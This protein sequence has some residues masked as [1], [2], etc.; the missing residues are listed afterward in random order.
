MLMV[1]SG[2]TIRDLFSGVGWAQ[3]LESL[4]L[5]ETGYDSDPAVCAT[6][7]LHGWDTRCQ[8]VT[9]LSP[10]E[11]AGTELLIASPPCQSWSTA[12]KLAGFGDARGRLVWEVE[13]IASQARP[14]VILCEQVPALLPVWRLIGHRLAAVGYSWWV[15][16]LSAEQWGV[17]QARRR[18]ILIARR[19][20]RSPLPPP[21]THRRYRIGTTVEEGDE[22]LLPWRS[23]AD[24]LGLPAEPGRWILDRRQNGA[25]TIDMAL[26]P[27][28]TLTAGAAKSIWT[29]HEHGR[30][31]PFT[32]AH[33]LAVQ[34]FPSDFLLPGG[35]REHKARMIGNAVPPVF[36]RA[37]VAHLLTT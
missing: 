7:E 37:L 22:A 13:R 1:E 6:R 33:A 10:D 4:G 15:G 12:G 25:P 29:I 21:P 2:V 27:A 3:A 17:P 14:R 30:R 31:V 8:D 5:A 9:T 16:I 28:P 11:F 18:A 26:A 24:A 35:P 34:S 32:I 20:G 36:G 19:D 23:M